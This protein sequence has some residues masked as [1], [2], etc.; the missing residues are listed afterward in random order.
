MSDAVLERKTTTIDAL[1]TPRAHLDRKRLTLFGLAIV[2]GLGSAWYGVHWWTVGRFIVS[3]DDAY[4]GGDI[5]VIAPEVPGFIADVAITDNQRVHT[6]DLL[7]KLDDR[8]YRAALAKAEAAVAAEQATLANLQAKRQVQQA[9][10]SEAQAEI[11]A[12]DAE[13][14]RAR[15]DQARYR[16][17]SI[18]SFAASIQTFQKADADYAKAGAASDRARAALAAAQHQMDVIDTERQQTEAARAG[19]IASRDTAQLNLGYTELRAPVDGMVGN[20]SARVG[21]Y[22]STGTQL[23]SI[24]PAHGLWIDANFKESQLAHLETGLPVTVEADELPGKVFHGHVVSLA[25]ATGAMFSVLPPENATGN[26]T[27]IVQRVPVRIV[28]DQDGSQL[29]PLRPGLSVTVDV[30]E[31]GETP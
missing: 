14:V 4:V 9:L 30:D 27:K 25:P 23:L 6:G 15:E 1:A 3:T 8:D 12:A 2:I 21:A 19:A 31:R 17:L 28:L 10:I 7:V 16:K 20:R 29:G 18:D 13:T 11:V 24:V 26:F 22:A 5:T